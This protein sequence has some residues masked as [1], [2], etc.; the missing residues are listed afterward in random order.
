MVLHFEEKPTV[1][2][3]HSSVERNM[4]REFKLNSNPLLCVR[5]PSII[6]CLMQNVTPG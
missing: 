3:F 2:S 5:I 4:E 1:R 6:D